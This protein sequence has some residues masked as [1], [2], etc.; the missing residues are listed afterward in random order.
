MRSIRIAGLGLVAACALS[1][2]AAASASASAPEYGRCLKQN[3][4]VGKQF[5]D[6]KCTKEVEKGSSKDKYEWSPGAG[7]A[8]FTTTGGVGVLTT[9]GGSGVECK[10]ESSN[11][12]FVPGNNKEEAGVVVKFTGCVS[13]NQPCTSPGAKAGELMTNELEGIVGWENKASK[14]TDLELFPAKSVASG[15]FIEFSCSGLVI[16]VKGKVLVPIKNDKMTSTETLKFKASKGKQ[17]P[18]KWEESPEKAILEAAFSNFKGGAFE[19]A[20]QNITATVKGEEQLELN[21]VV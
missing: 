3:T 4:G 21:A 7:K 18:E 14:K 11:G 6:S 8:K 9:V 16:K 20:G 13:L 15:L 5:S 12:E 17:K 19:Q 1:V 2:L 10:A